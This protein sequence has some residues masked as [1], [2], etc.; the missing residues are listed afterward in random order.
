MKCDLNN[1]RNYKSQRDLGHLELKEGG[2]GSRDIFHSV[3]VKIFICGKRGRVMPTILDGS[4]KMG[5]LKS[6]ESRRERTRQI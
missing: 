4:L 3:D 2:P 5:I 1:S 6:G